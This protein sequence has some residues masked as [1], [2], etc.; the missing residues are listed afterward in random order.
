MLLKSEVI[1]FLQSLKH[2]FYEYDSDYDT[3]G[4]IDALFSL[5][6]NIKNIDN[7]YINIQLIYDI[8]DDLRNTSI[9]E[10]DEKYDE[11]YG[12]ALNALENYIINNQ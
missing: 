1:D 11:E 10:E 2:D 5:I 4:F 3:S 9:D 12:D 8:I 6:G 7:E